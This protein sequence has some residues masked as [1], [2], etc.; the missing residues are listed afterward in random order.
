MQRSHTWVGFPLALMN[1]KA[2]EKLRMTLAPRVEQA[3]KRYGGG[4]CHR[5]S[6]AQSRHLAI[7][8]HRPQGCLGVGEET[9]LSQ[10]PQTLPAWL[11]TLFP[12]RVEVTHSQAYSGHSVLSVA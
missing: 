3:E 6:R 1:E 12:T 11:R 5:R 9:A 4:L 7:T 10:P 8:D 2:T